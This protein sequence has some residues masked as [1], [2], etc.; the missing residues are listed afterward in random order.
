MTDPLLPEEEEFPRPFGAYLLLHPLA[1][2][3][4]G[5]VYHAKT[6]SVA[7][8]EKR[9]V[10]KTLRPHFTA[11]REYVARF[12]DEAR[13]VVQLT[14]KNIASVFDV[15][16]VGGQFYLAMDYIAGRDV[17]TIQERLAETGRALSE[18]AALYAITET[19]DALDYAHRATDPNTGK[20]LNLVHRDVSPQ[21]VMVNFEGD[22]KLIDFG[23]AASTLK[24]EKT[25]PN[26]VMG[27][28]AYMSPEQARGEDVDGRADLFAVGVVCYELV[29]GSRYYD[30]M[31]PH[32]IWAAAGSGE[33]SSKVLRALS[34]ELMGI[35]AHSLAPDM[36]RRYPTCADFREALETY[37][38]NR[39]IRSGDGRRE[40]RT[41]MEEL[42]GG[43]RQ[44]E[45][46][47]YARFKDVRPIAAP[48]AQEDSQSFAAVTPGGTFAP[49]PSTGPELPAAERTETQAAVSLK[50]V[51]AGPDTEPTEAH[52]MAAGLSSRK[53][54]APIAAGLG[55]F[56]LVAGVLSLVLFGGEPD[57]KVAPPDDPS[58]VPTLVADAGATAPQADAG[59]PATTAD[60]GAPAPTPPVV[61]KPPPTTTKPTTRKRNNRRT[62]R[63][64][65]KPKPTG[66]PK[67]PRGLSKLK[68]YLKKHCA[69]MPCTKGALR[70]ANALQNP[71]VQ[72]LLAAKKSAESCARQCY[73]LK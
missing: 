49:P 38:Y 58:T 15:G 65:T 31:T 29:S 27:K 37:M 44:A 28:V 54:M 17:R 4:M 32:E 9:C 60:A 52:A 73:A 64:T 24:G 7:G 18:A 22:V 57:E 25:E 68:S 70:K 36:E 1:E 53:K 10:V 16:K 40:M 39:G 48:V 23:L 5:S 41:I 72:E 8:L 67:P 66:K 21:N 34:P 46:E 71:S 12:I 42:F 6:G 30:G 33:H 55:A 14:H 20:E 62:G 11:D 51:R 2:G 45:R 61:D 3:G 69:D 26:L 35:L 59:A 47:L 63:R 19:L 43:E 13:V 56:V 50:V